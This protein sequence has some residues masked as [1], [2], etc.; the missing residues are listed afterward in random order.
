MAQVIIFHFWV[1]NT[2][3][4]LKVHFYYTLHKLSAAVYVYLFVNGQEIGIRYL[5]SAS[6]DNDLR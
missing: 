2:T 4:K 6:A 3:L 1:I 5:K